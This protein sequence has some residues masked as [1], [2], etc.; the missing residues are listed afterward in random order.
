MPHK[1]FTIATIG[2]LGM[3]WYWLRHRA[4][5]PAII[6]TSGRGKTF[7]KELVTSIR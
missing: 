4:V 5:L 1:T 3:R 2:G 7:P 6:I